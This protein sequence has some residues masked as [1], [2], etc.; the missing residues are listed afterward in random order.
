MKTYRVYLAVNRPDEAMWQGE[1][2]N[3]KQA[4]RHARETFERGECE[5]TECFLDDKLAGGVSVEEQD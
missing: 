3:E 5:I 2:K 1:A 4:E